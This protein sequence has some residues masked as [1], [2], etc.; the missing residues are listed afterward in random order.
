MAFLLVYAGLLT[1][2][3]GFVSILKP[4]RFLRIRTRRAGAY[5]FASGLMLALAGTALPAP[6]KYPRGRH[7]LI[8]D[9]M[10][11]YQFNEIHSTRIQAPPDRIFQA[12]KAVTPE[13]IRFFRTLTWI[14][15][16]RLKRGTEETLLDAA[17]A[18]PILDVAVRSGFLLLAEETDREIVLGAV[19]CCS[20]PPRITTPQE[21]L[22]FNPPGYAKASLN[23]YLEEEGGGWSKVTTETRV[24]AT[25]S[26]ARRKFA[27]YWRVIYP[28][29][30]LIRRMWLQAIKRRAEA[31]R[32]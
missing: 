20:K 14:R 10:P 5:I 4:L 21:F 26:S 29:S 24:F 11:A 28:G 23:F 27:V 22:A 8:D 19:V 7:L 1:A 12:I 32:S 15:S 30:A 31:F 6:T 2:L 3:A 9:F 13:E 18:K 16:P 25:D 17:P